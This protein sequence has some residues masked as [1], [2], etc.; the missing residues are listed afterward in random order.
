MQI[1]FMPSF[2]IPPTSP[3]GIRL[4]VLRAIISWFMPP[5][6]MSATILEG[7]RVDCIVTAV[8]PASHF[9]TKATDLNISLAKHAGMKKTSVQGNQPYKYSTSSGSDDVH[10]RVCMEFHFMCVGVVHT[11]FPTDYPGGGTN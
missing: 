4:I 8:Q 2:G 10:F 11:Q 1:F 5:S 3:A 7:V 9:P 6:R